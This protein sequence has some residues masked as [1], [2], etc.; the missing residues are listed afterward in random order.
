MSEPF[1]GEVRAFP[2]T[3][4]P[5]NWAHCYG[6]ELPIIQ[7]QALFSLLGTAFGGDGRKTF[8]LPDLQGRA[9]VHMDEPKSLGRQS[10]QALHTLTT[11]EI[12][13][14]NHVL[15]A[16]TA[17]ATEEQPAEDHFP[18][19]VPTGKL[20]GPLNNSAPL[21]SG[22]VAP[23]GE[24]RPYENRQPSLVLNYCIALVGHFPMR[25]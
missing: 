15:A 16:T 2:F 1:F 11:A 19:A 23:A 4:A 24:G 8:R 14:H 25:S 17:A 9:T 18:A 12:S 3:F 22:T 7:H 21:F 13:V 20:Y 6:Q 5:R 10:G